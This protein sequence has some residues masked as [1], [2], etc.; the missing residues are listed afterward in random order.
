MNLESFCFC[1]VWQIMD[2][3]KHFL[4]CVVFFSS[5]QHMLMKQQDR[6]DD[7]V[8]DI[9]EQLYKLESD[10]VLVEVKTHWYDM[11]THTSVLL[12]LSVCMSLPSP[13]TAANEYVR[14]WFWYDMAVSVLK[15]YVGLFFLSAVL[16][17]SLRKMYYTSVV[18]QNNTVKE[19]SDQIPQISDLDPH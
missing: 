17:L 6:I 11:S 8:K 13:S 19:R 9:E 15:P 7:R 2:L 10:K 3:W 12:C 4:I 5:L 16:F 1:W 14:G 18:L